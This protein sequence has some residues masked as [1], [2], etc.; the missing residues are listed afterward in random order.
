MSWIAEIINFSR[1]TLLC[2][3]VNGSKNR[4]TFSVHEL[5]V[6]NIARQNCILRSCHTQLHNCFR[7][8]GI[9]LPFSCLLMNCWKWMR[10]YWIASAWPACPRCIK[11]MNCRRC[12]LNSNDEFCEVK[13]MCVW[14]VYKIYIYL[15]HIYDGCTEVT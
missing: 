15:F 13:N 4:Q 12:N 9:S 2:L 5:P 1:R 11:S 7:E 6:G 14:T 3:L 10:A 8:H